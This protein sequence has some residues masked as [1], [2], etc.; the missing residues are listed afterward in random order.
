MNLIL[1]GV[2]GS[3]KTTVG[4]LLAQRLAWTFLDADDFHPAANIEK[5]RQSIPLTDADRKPWLDALIARLNQEPQVHNVLACSALTHAIRQRLNQETKAPCRFVYLK[6]DYAVLYERLANRRDH[7]A[8]PGLLESQLATLEVPDDALVVDA[9]QPPE[10]IC[11][12]I[13]AELGPLPR[14]R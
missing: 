9:E 4:R 3:G 10:S 7:F 1:M 14:T 11:D 6:A 13:V 5:M 12:R 2:S 8:K